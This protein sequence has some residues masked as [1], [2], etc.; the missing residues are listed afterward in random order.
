MLFKPNTTC[1]LIASPTQLER[2]SSVLASVDLCYTISRKETY[3]I[4]TEPS[5]DS[6]WSNTE[7]RLR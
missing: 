5:T 7:L 6:L 1:Y 3:V 2:T 4:T